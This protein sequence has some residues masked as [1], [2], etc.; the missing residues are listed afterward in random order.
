[1][2]ITLTPDNGPQA[3][4]GN[5]VQTG[6]LSATTTTTSACGIMTRLIVGV[7]IGASIRTKTLAVSLN[8]RRT[9]SFAVAVWACTFQD[10]CHHRTFISETGLTANGGSPT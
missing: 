2:V 10:C 3:Q 6:E 1:M 9:A 4:R 8:S 5:Q 7:P